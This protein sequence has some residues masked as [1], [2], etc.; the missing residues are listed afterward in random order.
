MS[1]ARDMARSPFKPWDSDAEER[2]LRRAGAR[3]DFAQRIDARVA[4]L[5]RS[6]RNEQAPFDVT[7]PGYT[8]DGQ[9]YR[10]LAGSRQ[11]AIDTACMHHGVSHA[12]RRHTDASAV[13]VRHG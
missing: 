10:V 11:E 12:M 7:L 2:R 1:G 9:P 6:I 3:C 5:R 8:P 4:D 13:E